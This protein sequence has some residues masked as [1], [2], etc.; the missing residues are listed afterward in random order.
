MLAKNSAQQKRDINEVKS[1]ILSTKYETNP[2]NQNSN[3]QNLR[4][5]F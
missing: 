4:V 5:E 1:E 2:N 3:N